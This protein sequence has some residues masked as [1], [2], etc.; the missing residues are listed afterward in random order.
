MAAA[1]RSAQDMQN[2]IVLLARDSD[3][4]AEA[5]GQQAQGYEAVSTILDGVFARSTAKALATQNALNDV[6]DEVAPQEHAAG[7]EQ[8]A[9]AYEA[10]GSVLDGLF[11]DLGRDFSTIITGIGQELKRFGID[12]D[13]AFTG[14]TRQIQDLFGITT[15]EL[16]G[17]ASLAGRTL[18]AFGADF[19]EVFGKKLTKVIQLFGSFTQDE[20]SA[21]GKS[22]SGVVDFIGGLFGGGAG[23]AAGGAGAA[24]GGG[25]GATLSGAFTGVV[26]T[27]SN[28][29]NPAVASSGLAITDVVSASTLE[30]DV[31]SNQFAGTAAAAG[32]VGT[33]VA[34]A[35]SVRSASFRSFS[36]SNDRDRFIMF[37]NPYRVTQVATK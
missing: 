30:L 9:S 16:R 18:E 37:H 12:F 21:I 15:D 1:A 35:S 8:I 34:G 23:G 7:I 4:A 31:L 32:T 3:A 6:L 11:G 25:L 17:F 5:A 24:G 33:E 29:F 26:D 27:I 10:L 22:V 13:Q 2:A 14:L 19:E 28:F 20:F 36:G